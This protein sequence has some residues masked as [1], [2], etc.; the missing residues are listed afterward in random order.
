M[1]LAL[2][3]LLG[4]L[5]GACTASRPT[6]PAQSLPSDHVSGA[7][8]LEGVTVA[9]LLE[10]T[11]CTG[12]WVSE[13]SILTAKHCVHDGVPVV[14]ATHA[15]LFPNG[16]L[17]ADTDV[18][19]RIAILADTDD[20]HDLAL[21]YALKRP[22][23]H[24][25]ALLHEGP[26]SQGSFAQSMGH[27]RGLWFT[28]STGEVSAIREKDFGDGTGVW[29][30]STAPISPGNSGGGLFDSEAR[31]IGIADA[32]IEGGSALNL[33]VHVQYVKRFLGAQA[34]L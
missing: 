30:Q 3:F 29:V 11:M 10:G 27:P 8:A 26:V 19:A 21:L 9:L 20:A 5:L 22:A 25:V 34:A 32:I 6:A 31:L 28:Y 24:A 1:R 18:P 16:G 33:F 13:R 23:P 4:M 14:Y 12:V 17:E 2:T 7:A 15:D